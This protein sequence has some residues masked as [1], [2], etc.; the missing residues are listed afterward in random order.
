MT[1]DFLPGFNHDGC[2]GKN[3]KWF[4]IV[5]GLI[6]IL[7]IAL[8]VGLNFFLLSKGLSTDISVFGYRILHLGVAKVNLFPN[9]IASAFEVVNQQNGFPIRVGKYIQNV[10]I[11]HE[12][13]NIV[14][15]TEIGSAVQKQYKFTNDTSYMCAAP[16]MVTVDGAPQQVDPQKD[17]ANFA[18]F[19]NGD[20]YRGDL[21]PN[22]IIDFRQDLAKGDA[23]KLYLLSPAPDSDGMFSLVHVILFTSHTGCVNM[24]YNGNAVQNPSVTPGTI[25]P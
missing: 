5:P 3:G 14:Y 21:A 22:A 24:L 6:V 17:I 20:G 25:T 2:M 19:F 9:N 11:D 1:L 4:I 18:F 8:I 13:D 12:S 15:A 7:L 10:T 16:Q 23:A